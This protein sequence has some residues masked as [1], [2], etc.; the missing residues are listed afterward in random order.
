MFIESEDLWA[1]YFAYQS[2]PSSNL[3]VTFE[4]DKVYHQN[5]IQAKPLAIKE[6]ND[7]NP[8][9]VTMNCYR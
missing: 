7:K 3:S 4:D 8:N 5:A 9:I 6:L 2:Y 1:S